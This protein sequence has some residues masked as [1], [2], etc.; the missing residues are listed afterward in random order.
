MGERKSH[1][2]Q[3]PILQFTLSIA[4]VMPGPLAPKGEDQCVKI[5]L[6]KKKK[7]DVIKRYICQLKRKEREREREDIPVY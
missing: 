3:I 7:V 6:K 4:R 1:V 5:A 2:H